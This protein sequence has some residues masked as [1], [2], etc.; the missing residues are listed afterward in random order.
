MGICLLLHFLDN[1]PDTFRMCSGDHLEKIVR[2]GF[3]DWPLSIVYSILGVLDLIF[4]DFLG[5]V[6]KA[7]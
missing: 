5:R 4:D 2:S 7:T 3:W 1:R 6:I